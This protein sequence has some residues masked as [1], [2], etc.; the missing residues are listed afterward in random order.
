MHRIRKQ[1]WR[2]AAAQVQSQCCYLSLLHIPLSSRWLWTMNQNWIVPS[3]CSSGLYLRGQPN[4]DK[5]HLGER[6]G[7]RSVALFW[8]RAGTRRGCFC[9]QPC[10][11][12][13]VLPS[14]PKEQRQKPPQKAL[15]GWGQGRQDGTERRWAVLQPRCCRTGY[16]YSYRLK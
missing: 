11:Q 3:L 15:W 8:G 10:W 12:L 4:G 7:R 2:Q 14:Q 9:P 5:S 1:S 16:L 13:S 6:N